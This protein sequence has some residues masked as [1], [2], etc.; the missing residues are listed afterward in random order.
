MYREHHT[1]KNSRLNTNEDL[2][3]TLLFTSD[4]YISSLPNVP[5]KYAQEFSED[6]KKLLKPIDSKTDEE[7]MIDLNQSLTEINLSD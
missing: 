3:H 4:P 7:I 2:I 5:K 6:V 1:R